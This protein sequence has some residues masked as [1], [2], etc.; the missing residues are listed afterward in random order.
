MS[1]GRVV[2]ESWAEELR[3]AGMRIRQ[4][5]LE[6]CVRHNGG[7]LIQA[8]GS[9]D[10]LA[11]L[12]LRLM[13]LGPSSGPLVP[14]KFE[15]VPQPGA[16]DQWGG[17]YNGDRDRFFLSPAH[18]A[19]ALYSTLIEAGRLAD[20][21]LDQANDDGSTLE[22]IGAE[23]SPGF[24]TTAG[25]LG[26]ALSVA[27]GTALARKRQQRP[28]HVWAFISDG[29]LEEG[30]TWEA[31]A[32]AVNFE[33]DNLTV[34]LD[35]NGLQVDTWVRDVMNIEPIVDKVHAFGVKVAEADGHDPVAIADAAT[36]GRP[37]RPLFVV[38]RTKPTRG[39]EALEGRHQLH[40]IRFRDGEVQA[41]RESLAAAQQEVFA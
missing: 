37:G 7:Y 24:E 28:G 29:E 38:C 13:D 34:M 30:Q 41:A 26:Q 22:M 25:S 39:I 33:L 4:R 2:V 21:T 32:A 36:S 19:L 9:A 6:V 15:G 1:G 27:V 14:A 31:L 17:I 20:D 5:A 8:C 23:H 40:Y 11:T 35:A 18:Y 16:D 3:A 10:I 12:Y